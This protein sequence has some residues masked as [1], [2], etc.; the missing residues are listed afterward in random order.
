MLRVAARR[1][2]EVQIS[3]LAFSW[4]DRGLLGGDTIEFLRKEAAVLK[5]I[6]PAVQGIGD[7]NMTK[8]LRL[9]ISLIYNH[10][11]KGFKQMAEMTW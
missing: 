9:M 4:E 2:A 7:R 10:V 6:E 1:Y 5:A 8:R 11:L 3:E